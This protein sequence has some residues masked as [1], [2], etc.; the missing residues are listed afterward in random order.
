MTNR[1][2]TIGKRTYGAG[3]LIALAVLFIGVTIL[4]TFLFR[5]ARIDLTESKLYSISD[6][7]ERIVTSLE[8]P[9]NL[10][11]FFSQEAS[12]QSPQ[13]RAYAQRVRE[14]L[15]EIA[16]RSKGKLRLSVID[17]QPFSEEEDRAAEFGLSAV[18]IGASGES[19]YFGLAGTN[20]TDGR[21]IIGFFQPDKE[22]F[23]EYDVASLIYR[24]GN[25]QRAVV[26]LLSS[27]PVDASFD[28][29]SGQ[30]QQGWA[31]VAQLRELFDVRT[32]AT[33]AAAI[34]AEI[35][36]L[37]LI[38]PKDLSPQ[39]LYAIDQF[40]MRGGK[41][42]AFVD[43]QAENDASGGQMGMPPMGGRSSS[44][45]PLLDAYGVTFDPSTVLG[46]RELGL[47]VSLRQGQPPSQ[48][49][50]II[51]FNRT[52]MGSNDVVTA[53]LDTVNVMTAGTLAKKEDATIEFEP[54]LQSSTNAALIPAA[55]LAFL[56]DSDSLLDGFK[57]T[58]ERYTVA[59]RIR[60]KLKSAYP[61]GE[62]ESAEETPAGEGSPAAGG[63]HRAETAEEA[64]IIL[65]A[66]TDVLADPLWIRTQNV[67]G[68]HFAVAWANNGDFIANALDNLAGSSDL[69]SIRGRQSFFRPF[70][71]VDELRRQADDQLR[72]KE[73]ELDQQLQ[74]TERKLSELEAERETQGSLVLSPEQEA[75]LARFQQERVRIRKEL[76]D[77]RR[78]LDLE[79]ERLGTVLKV[80]NIA[81]VPALIAIAAILLAIARRRRLRAGRAAAHT[82]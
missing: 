12:E 28:Q 46:D 32:V 77:V 15:E 82:A 57:A 40:V 20:S 22:E 63:E 61:D 78:S 11:F 34:D 38:H 21:E 79:I 18:P 3:A 37:L 2:L 74:V 55:R 31:S 68:Q 75:T 33:D 72:A 43:P 36:V 48:H 53:A 65:V 7:T 51:G 16:Q 70:T 81:L 60:G 62:P 49:I 45:D 52:S 29:M 27:L 80:V 4:I 39:T 35:G 64:N 19:L 59:A 1:T 17:P 25:P 42:I 69:I 26:G 54:L 10:Y 58:G 5:G 24:L 23:L 76:R 66:D 71:K 6:G 73:Q 8:E 41:L 14:L 9:V 30:M 67:F 50:A 44:L 56:P 13:L 47:T